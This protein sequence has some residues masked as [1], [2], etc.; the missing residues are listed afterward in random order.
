MVRVRCSL[1]S[2]QG[3]LQEYGQGLV[4]PSP[5]LEKEIMCWEEEL[6]RKGGY[7]SIAGM[8]RDTFLIFP[9]R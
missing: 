2:G 8:G 4:Q 3:H 9:M 7:G 6:P 1:S 5:D